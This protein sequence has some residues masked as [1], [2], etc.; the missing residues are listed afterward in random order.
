MTT[1]AHLKD[2]LSV[3]AT[4]L[5]KL[6]GISLIDHL[7]NRLSGTYGGRWLKDFPDMRSIEN[8]K[9]AWA[10]G[11]DEEGLT[12]HDV[13]EGLRTCRRMSP[14]WPPS[15]GEFLRACRPGLVPENAFYDAVAGMA[16]RRRGELGAW[17]HP[18]VYWS[19]VNVGSHDL[20]NCGYSVMKT[21]WE[22][23]LAEELA[24]GVWR[25]IP[26]PSVALPAP[27]VTQAT[28]EEAAVALKKMGAG[29]C[30]NEAGRDPRR[31]A[32]VILAESTR[33][34]GRRYSPT[35]LAM[36]KAALASCV[37]QGVAA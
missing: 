15:L 16:A 36:A 1:V 33:E 31:G 28:R 34:G 24:R 25:E 20:L 32:K 35:V 13:A 14:D 29:A 30:L 17:C 3:W 22:R 2:E 4:P 27:G 10:E 8:W 6:E 37:D 12:P 5:A 23:A 26:T 7:W 9:A 21:R 19:A 18:A 11:F